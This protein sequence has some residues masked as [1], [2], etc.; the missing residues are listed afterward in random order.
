MIISHRHQFIFFAVPK[1]A[2]HA[3]RRALREHLGETDEEQV[4]LFVQKTMPYPEIARVRHGHIR[5]NECKAAVLPDV[6]S[7]YFKFAFVR[8][9][10]ERF[11]S[12]CAF[13]YRQ[14]QLFQ[15]DPKNTMR[16]VLNS[17]EHRQRVVFRPQSE[18]LCD[19]SD[20]VMLDFVGRHESLQADFD[21]ICNRIGIPLAQLGRANESEHGPWRDYYDATLK[22]QV[23]ELYRR[24]IEIFNFKFD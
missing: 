7:S 15:R 23:A 1:T 13:M 11:V 22:A 3:I 2:T 4:Q 10:W 6:W 24:D 5:W 21:T 17:P 19:E 18:F 16:A 14:Q 9:P 12:Y 20:R 8:N